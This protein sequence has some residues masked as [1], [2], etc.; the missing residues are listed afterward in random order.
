M[1]RLSV[2]EIYRN[3]LSPGRALVRQGPL[4][5]ARRLQVPG[6]LLLLGNGSTYFILRAP[7]WS[8][9]PFEKILE[10]YSL[11]FEDL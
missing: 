2:N 5:R 10:N 7:F 3:Q 4:G 8:Y 1:R 6:E 9:F 11:S